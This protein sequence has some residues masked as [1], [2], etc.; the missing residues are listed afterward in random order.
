M[1]GLDDCSIC[2]GKE[3]FVSFEPEYLDSRD[4]NAF[5]MVTIMCNSCKHER[6]AI[7]DLRRVYEK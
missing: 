6:D 5:I 1:T 2:G 4:A 3:F 7:F